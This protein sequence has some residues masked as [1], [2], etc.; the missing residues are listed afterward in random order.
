MY[1]GDD[2]T[3]DERR[4]FEDVVDR[5]TEDMGP[6]LIDPLRGAD[7]G[8]PNYEV[9]VSVT[10]V[11]DGGSRELPHDAS[12]TVRRVEP[13]RAVVAEFLHSGVVMSFWEELETDWDE[14][15]IDL[16][17]RGVRGAPAA[18]RGP[19]GLLPEGGV[20]ESAWTRLSEAAGP[21]DGGDRLRD[22]LGRLFT[23]IYETEELA[24]EAGARQLATALNAVGVRLQ[25]ALAESGIELP[26]SEP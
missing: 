6:G 25:R 20:A 2:L 19:T 16:Q 3:D 13:P 12:F 22:A 8:G 4:E 14:A 7:L 26:E 11:G 9:D 17:R 23:L 21:D 5:W 18:R 10:W 24:A 15:D 1:T